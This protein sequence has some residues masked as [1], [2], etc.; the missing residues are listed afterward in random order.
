[1]PKYNRIFIEFNYRKALTEDAEVKGIL[2]KDPD[3]VNRLSENHGFFPCFDDDRE[4]AHIKIGRG[5]WVTVRKAERCEH[6]FD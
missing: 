2:H 1:M 3:C 4:T 5:A 6:C